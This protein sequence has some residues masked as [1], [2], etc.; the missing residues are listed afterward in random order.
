MVLTVWNSKEI[1]Y[2]Y[3]IVQ[4]EKPSHKVKRNLRRSLKDQNKLAVMVL[5]NG[6]DIEKHGGIQ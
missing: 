3:M 1:Y 4:I 2:L 6:S 5:E